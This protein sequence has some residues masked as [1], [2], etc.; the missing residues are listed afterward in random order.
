MNKNQLKSMEKKLM[1]FIS[2]SL[3]VG[4]LILIVVDFTL[5]MLFK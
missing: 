2:Y 3:V 5:A 1:D 4:I